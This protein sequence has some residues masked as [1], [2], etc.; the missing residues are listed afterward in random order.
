MISCPLL[1]TNISCY[2]TSQVLFCYWPRSNVQAKVKNLAIP[3]KQK[4]KKY[5]IRVFSYTGNFLAM[6]LNVGWMSMNQDK[7]LNGFRFNN[8]FLSLCSVNTVTV[9]IN[10]DIQYIQ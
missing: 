1:Y 10:R 5:D 6:I 2:I 3:D 4:W 7:S 9:V 8:N